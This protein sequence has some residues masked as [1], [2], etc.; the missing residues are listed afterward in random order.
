MSKRQRKLSKEPISTTI[1][2]L[3]HEG[4]GI[5]EING[6]TTF[7]FNALP[8]EEVVCYYTNRRSQFDE[9]N[10]VEILN[11][12]TH[13]VEPI[14]PHFSI[15]G[16]CDLQHMNENYQIELK[17]TTVL[18]L[19]RNTPPD[20]VL[21]PL[22]ANK[23]G[24]RRKA[25]IGVKYVTKKGKVLVGFRE[26]NTSYVCD[27]SICHTLHPN[28][29][30]CLTEL[31]ELIDEL[32]AKAQIPQLE[33][34]VADDHTAIILRH[35]TPLLESDQEKIIQFFDQKKWHLYL[36][37]G[38]SETIHKV[39][40]ADGYD[41]LNYYLADKKLRFEFHPAQFT[42]INHEINHKMVNQA[43]TLLELKASDTVLDLFC[44]IGN[45]SLPI[46]QQ[47]HKVV[48]VEGDTLAVKQ[49]QKNASL[50]NL[51]NCE[52]YVANLFDDCTNTPWAQQTFDKLLLDPPRSGA[53]EI[54]PHI[55]RWQPKQIVY[56]SCNP[57]TLARDAEILQKQDYYLKKAGIM[58]MFPQTKHVEVIALFE[59]KSL[60]QKK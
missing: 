3:S 59:H 32:S 9:A 43:L 50:N 18:S 16:G 11:A 6:K 41:R 47:V 57:A 37:P 21:A 29:G 2:R 1:K 60:G 24:Y 14:C 26:R 13:R 58:D 12:S 56:V 40:P 54:I 38:N 15:C 7:V 55:A 27:L 44:G 23:T 19:L 53:Q 51:F 8:D 10:A 49:A 52:F 30:L 45:F 4:R 36:Q 25:R 34:A 42:Q 22:T 48:G 17:Q 28:L 5:A 35:L 33:I 31:S 20:E 39:Y 46:A